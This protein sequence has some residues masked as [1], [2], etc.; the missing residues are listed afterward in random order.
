MLVHDGT[1]LQSNIRDIPLSE[2]DAALR[3][4]TGEAEC[5]VRLRNANWISLPMQS[6]G[7][8]YMLR[9]LENVDQATGPVQA[10]LHSLFLT[11]A[12]VSVLIA[13][14]CSIASSRSIVQPIAA[15][16]T[17]LRN[18]VSTGLLPEFEGKSSSI[19]EIKQ[20][21]D[22]YNHAAVSVRTA[23]ED[24]QSAYLEFVGSLANALDARD[25]Y[26]AGHSLRVSQLSCAIAI[27]MKLGHAD[28]ERIRIGALL[29]DMGKIGIADS[30][31]QKPGRLTDEE[32]AIV[33]EHPV[34][35]RRILEGVQG[36][37]PFLGA[38][39][40]HHENWDGSGYP[41]G[42]AGEQTPV[43]ARII[44]V[45]DAYDAMTTNRS[46]RLG[47]TH[48]RAIQILFDYAG[49]QFDPNVVA[50][51]AALPRPA[52]GTGPPPTVQWSSQDGLLAMV[53][54]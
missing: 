28:V 9:S 23:G 25:R 21:T 31:L 17:H 51:F 24:L 18:A 45:A 8:S 46:Y 20:L 12:L 44:H 39:E 5:D 43:D 14:L 47:L 50:I 22:S 1:A 32:F 36:L 53:T 34:I 52:A 10:K 3:G 49:I 29:H 41:K 19:L 38:V 4:C 11:V 30:V 54:I 48:E 7:D 37:A 27:A 42:Q 2:I 15:M 16:V 6:F 40:L 33:K 26:T 13:F 35:G